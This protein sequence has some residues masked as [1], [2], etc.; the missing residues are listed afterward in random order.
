M[1]KTFE[2]YYPT[3]PPLESKAPSHNRV[4]VIILRGVFRKFVRNSGR[5]RYFNE[6][7][8]KKLKSGKSID[9]MGLWRVDKE[10]RG[11]PP[12]PH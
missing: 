12:P 2:K 10:N 1:L 5:G 6:G 7:G 11:D 4:G 9:K 8:F 3:T